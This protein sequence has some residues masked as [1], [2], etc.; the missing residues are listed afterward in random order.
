MVEFFI[1]L[2]SQKTNAQLKHKRWDGMRSLHCPALTAYD[3][4]SGNRTIQMVPLTNLLLVGGSNGR[5]T[6]VFGG[7]SLSLGQPAGETPERPREHNRKVEAV[8]KQCLIMTRGLR[9]H[10]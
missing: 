9:V 5:R 7:C 3:P 6:R 8:N 10:G 2:G 4:R 1:F